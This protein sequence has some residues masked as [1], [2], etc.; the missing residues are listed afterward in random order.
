MLLLLTMNVFS[1]NTPKVTVKDGQDLQLTDLQVTVDI[2]GNLAVTTYDMEFYNGLNRTLEG[3]LVFP[4]G[5]GQSVSGFAMDVNGTMRDAVIVEKEL[6]RVAYETTIRRKIDPGLL[7]KTEGNNYKARIYPIFPKSSKHIILK[8]EQE[9]SMLDGK[10]S[11][12]VPLGI[13]HTLTNFSIVMNVFSGAQPVVT[14]TSYNDFYFQKNGEAYVATVSKNNH[15][16]TEPIAIQIRNRNN[17]EHMATY[18]EYFHYYKSL[19]PTFRLKEKPKKITILWDASYS[20]RYRAIEKELN[21][22][23]SYLDY[24]RDVKVDLIVF[25]NTIQ[26]EKTFKIKKGDVS[27]LL[28]AIRNVHYDGGTK[29][30][31]FENVKLNTDEILLFSDGLANLGDF[32]IRRKIPVYAINSLVSAN[33]ESLQ[34]LTTQSGGNYLNLLRLDYPKAAQLLKKEIYQFLGVKHNES[35]REVYPKQRVNVYQDFSISGQFSKD[36]T[37]ELLFGYGGKVSEKIPV[38]IYATNGTKEVRRLW[39]KQKLGVLNQHKTANKNAIVSLA[40]QYDL[41]TDYTSMI[42]LDRIQDYVR[43]KIEPPAELMEQYTKLLAHYERQEALRKQ[44][45]VN[46]KNNLQSTYE[47][48]KNWYAHEF[49]NPDKGDKRWGEAISVTGVIT[50]ESG[51]PLPV[52]T[53]HI[54]GMFRGTQSD[55][56]GNYKIDALIGETLVF[57]YIGYKTV[58]VLVTSNMIDVTMKED[59]EL[60]DD[61]QIVAYASGIKKDEKSMTTVATKRIEQIPIKAL[62]DELEDVTQQVQILDGSEGSG[63]TVQSGSHAPGKQKEILMRSRSSIPSDLPLYVVDGKVVDQHTFQQLKKEKI[64][65]VSVLKEY[66]ATAIYGTR[67]AHG[68]IIVTTKKVKEKIALKSWN[69]NTLYILALQNEITVE[70]AYKKYLEIRK[71]YAD[72]PT[73]YVDVADFFHSRGAT[74]IAVTVIT[75]LIEIKLNDHELLKAAA[76]KLEYFKR[77]EMAVTVYEKILELRPEEPQSYRDVALAYEQIGKIQESYD[78]LYTLYDGQLIEKD[79]SGRFT[80]IENIAFIELTRL[81]NLYKKELKLTKAQQDIFSEMPMDIRVV[82]DWNHDNTNIDLWVVDPRGERASYNNRRTLIGGL[83]S[84]NIQE[85]Y[86]PETFLMKEVMKGT[87]KVYVNH[88]SHNVQK[89]TGPTIIKVTM[90]RNY[91]KKNEEKK[92]TVVHLEKR[93][94][95]IEIGSLLFE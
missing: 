32:A 77:Y 92:V 27:N 15:A 22:L 90:Y 70:A 30:N 34:A 46:R 3:E 86:G 52:A 43:Y 50:D 89:I 28:A 55:F 54:K 93:S 79:E 31:L 58:E 57:S 51:Y 19:Q 88:Y 29:L 20:M 14:K 11:Y 45:I 67:G 18:N 75:N 59:Y 16:P 5:E 95:T 62:D 61:L 68:V 80:G 25:N 44:H 26:T 72:I 66:A 47:G 23:T 42:I 21:V 7:E 74:A 24:L 65:S 33:H 39:A 64:E 49:L 71:Q 8:F 12:D 84:N 4:L 37:I 94:G 69:P 36:A 48:I 85:G 63:I 2:V 40:K 76:Y 83:L 56:D 38:K 73:F 60:L 6:G 82:I 78:V 9:L 41:I 17:Q 81:V 91:G 13:S 53:I 35:V 10:Q 1:Q 87:Y